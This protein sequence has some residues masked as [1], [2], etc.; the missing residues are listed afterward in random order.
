[1][2]Q[3]PHDPDS[4]ERA[5]DQNNTMPPQEDDGPSEIEAFGK[6]GAGIAAK[7]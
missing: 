6:E 2:S 1:M 7:K 3:N 5:L 4:A